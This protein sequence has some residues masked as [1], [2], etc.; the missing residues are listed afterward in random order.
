MNRYE[1][2]ELGGSPDLEALRRTDELLDRLGRREPVARDL[3]DPVAAALAVLAGDVDLDLVPA[4]QTRAA[5]TEAGLWP[6]PGPGE[7]AGAQ[8]QP[9]DRDLQQRRP[10]VGIAAPRPMPDGDALW[11]D[12]AAQPTAGVRTR[13]RRAAV[14]ARPE[15]DHPWVLRIRPRAGIAAAAV[16][17]LLGGGV[18]AAVTSDSINPLT[19]IAA[20]VARLTDSRTVAQEQAQTQV[21][22]KLA[23]AWAAAR[24]G[25]GPAAQML[26]AAVKSQI[27]NLAG[28]DQKAISQQI[29]QL[30]G[31]LTAVEGGWASPSD[32]A[33]ASSPAADVTSG[34]AG[35]QVPALVSTSSGRVVRSVHRSSGST[36][37]TSASG[38]SS[39]TGGSSRASSSAGWTFTG[40]PSDPGTSRPTLTRTAR[41]GGPPR[42]TSAPL[43]STTDPASAPST[44]ASDTSLSTFS[45]G[46]PEQG[47]PATSMPPAVSNPT[48]TG[49]PPVA[50][51]S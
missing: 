21:S 5:M 32:S 16:L 30:Q 51:T 11:A 14:P 13:G 26:I 8:G 36:A 10:D 6:L 24:T 35:S 27:H 18:S 7:R 46:A 25:N 15:L 37:A 17:V 42:V 39:S 29:N 38:S 12:P 1:G 19:G 40:A 44:S 3:D 45:S 31:A 34:P 23:Q 22:A 9:A 33:D 2:L 41:Y 48:A 4:M 28:Q 50:P 49:Q 43:A 20:A 47:A